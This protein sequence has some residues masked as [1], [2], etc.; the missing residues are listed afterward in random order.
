MKGKEI[1][2]M[3]DAEIGALQDMPIWDPKDIQNESYI[4]LIEVK[5]IGI[6]LKENHLR[7]AIQ[8]AATEGI[9]WVILTNGDKWQAHRVLFEK[10]VKTEVAF[11]FSF[12]E[13]KNIQYNCHIDYELNHKK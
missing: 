9:D 2:E 4:N 12:I 8:Y 3:L 11:E 10:P 1:I 7:Q 5:A 6:S 13:E